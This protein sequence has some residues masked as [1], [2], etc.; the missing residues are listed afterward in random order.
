MGTKEANAKKEISDL[1]EIMKLVE[2]K[3]KKGPYAT[4]WYADIRV[5]I[6]SRILELNKR[7]DT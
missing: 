6:D 4:K 1:H 2:Q 3:G 5:V 7:L